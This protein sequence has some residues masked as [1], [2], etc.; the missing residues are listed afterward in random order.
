MTD[1]KV[2]QEDLDKDPF[3]LQ[4][5]AVREDPKDG[6]ILIKGKVMKII[7]F[8]SETFFT[9][10]KVKVIQHSKTSEQIP[11]KIRCVGIAKNINEN[12]QVLL[13]AHIQDNKY[14]TS[15]NFDGKICVLTSNDQSSLISF[16]T[17]HIDGV[18][19]SSAQKIFKVLGLNAIT[20]I[21]KDPNILA[22]KVKLTP[23]VIKPLVLHLTE[24]AKFNSL[25]LFLTTN[26]IQSKY[27]VKLFNLL[28]INAELKIRQNPYLLINHDVARFKK[29]DTIAY[30]LG[31]PS[32]NVNRYVGIITE[33]LKESIN[34]GDSSVRFRRMR[35]DI[36]DSGASQWMRFHS[37]YPFSASDQ[38][39]N[40]ID[41][42]LMN[43]VVTAMMRKGWIKVYLDPRDKELKDG[44]PVVNAD[45]YYVYLRHS[46]DMETNIVKTVVERS[47][48]NKTNEDFSEDEVL[49]LLSDYES[50]KGIKLSKEQKEAVLTMLFNKLSIVTGSAGTGKSTLVDAFLDV[51]NTL[52][53]TPNENDVARRIKQVAEEQNLSVSNVKYAKSALL[54]PTG[55]AAQNL[56]MDTHHAAFTIHRFLKITPGKDD[57]LTPSLNQAK[58]I[59]IGN[60]AIIDESSMIDNDLFS[61]LLF[62]I[63][64]DTNI[65]FIGD[66][67]Q[68]PPVGYGKAFADI[69]N[70]GLVPI[71]KLKTVF[72]QDKSSIIFKND[73]NI[74]K[75]DASKLEF[76]DDIRQNNVFL[77]RNNTKD[78]IESLRTTVNDLIKN[79]GYDPKD[80]LILSPIHK[81]MVGVDNLNLLMQQEINPH[82]LPYNERD[83]KDWETNS[84]W[85]RS[86][87]GIT[88]F[89]G[90]RMLQLKNDYSDPH[91]EIA[92]GA[93]GYIQEINTQIVEK[94]DHYG[95]E[96]A[97]MIKKGFTVRFPDE[98][99][100]K[101]YEDTTQLNNIDLGYVFTVHKAQGS[102]FPVTICICDRSSDG[103]NK[104][105]DKTLLYTAATRAKE[106][107][108]FIGQ[109]DL[110]A[111]AI[112]RNTQYQRTSALAKRIQVEALIETNQ[113]KNTKIN[114]NTHKFED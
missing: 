83:P 32:K 59:F 94:R 97:K 34:E 107:M 58:N 6:S 101:S 53:E 48:N 55:K 25:L 29:C 30:K 38:F 8:D 70:S 14:G 51:Y 17:N 85:F 54:S 95:N 52:V 19:R 74:L 76:T 36:I 114:Y 41:S 12:D 86:N 68:L 47:L 24:I 26:D 90:D 45:K 46:Y 56:M 72:R 21:Q 88:Y 3:L 69:I 50:R 71:V 65:V 16:L 89:T 103:Y 42:V 9:T 66:P 113:L 73:Q 27:A 7:Y 49:N 18:G 110:F 93:I 1:L 31:F 111:R 60:Y 15:F 79:Q 10:M 99:V 39:S 67:N 102:G 11:D 96:T 4:E 109:K 78:I 81:G 87:H 84:L 77:E 104:F 62:A 2:T 75:G 91:A 61:T 28:G 35:Y 64:P 13:R 40:A 80:I 37:A 100:T 92:N 106:K 20:L 43:K 98:D 57:D 5:K 63:Q 33:Y 112:K 108:I 105:L 82:Y 23:K 22:S 44:K